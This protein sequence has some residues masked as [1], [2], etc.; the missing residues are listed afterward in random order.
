MNTPMRSLQAGAFCLFHTV[1]LAGP[2][3]PSAMPHDPWRAA[4]QAACQGDGI[5]L[6]PATEGAELRVVFQK[7]AGR[8]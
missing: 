6:K 3:A 8:V 7:L 2:S 1:L 5:S 4:A